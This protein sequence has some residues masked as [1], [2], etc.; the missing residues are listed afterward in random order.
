[1]ADRR[2]TIAW[3]ERTF[4]VRGRLDTFSDEPERTETVAYAAIRRVT[5]WQGYDRVCL[6]LGRQT[7]SENMSLAAHSAA[8]CADIAA[9]LARRMEACR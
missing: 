9:E 6:D 4:T 2:F 8:E 7:N 1:M 5:S 3:G